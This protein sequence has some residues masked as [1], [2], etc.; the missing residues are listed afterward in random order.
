MK[1]FVIRNF[2]P[3]VIYYMSCVFCSD[4]HEKRTFLKKG[5]VPDVKEVAWDQDQHEWMKESSHQSGSN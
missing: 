4:G 2:L 5:I 3:E 1:C